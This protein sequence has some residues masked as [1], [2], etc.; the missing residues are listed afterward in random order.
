MKYLVYGVLVS[1]GAMT[2]Y[3]LLF[4]KGGN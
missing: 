4:V 3:T 2:P 1:L